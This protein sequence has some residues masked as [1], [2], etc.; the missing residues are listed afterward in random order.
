MIPARTPGF[1]RT[2]E[3]C[4]AVTPVLQR[5]RHAKCFRPLVEKKVSH[6]PRGSVNFFW[7]AAKSVLH[8]QNAS[9]QRPGSFHRAWRNGH[10]KR[11]CVRVAC[12]DAIRPP[13]VGVLPSHGHF[14]R[15]VV[16]REIP[17]HVVCECVHEPD[18][19]PPCRRR[20]L[21]RGPRLPAAALTQLSHGSPRMSALA[22]RSGSATRR[23]IP[24]NSRA[25]SSPSMSA[26]LSG[27]SR[28]RTQ[29]GPGTRRHG[30]REAIG[31]P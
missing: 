17:P 19:E 27:S 1:A 31:R 11:T 4:S 2:S 20:H 6:R 7:A 26:G 28:R 23:S 18:G 13:G 3:A 12:G 29:T 22:D 30:A 25:P 14:G 8:E 10:R 9:D 16:R 5:A 15:S 21:S 24:T